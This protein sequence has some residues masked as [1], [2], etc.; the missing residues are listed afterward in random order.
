MHPILGHRR[1][2]A[3]YLGLWV[4]VGLLLAGT[5]WLAHPGSWAASL[6]VALPL[7]LLYAFQCLSSWYVVCAAPLPETRLGS[8]LATLGA[9]ATLSSLLWIAAGAG[10]S[11]L[12]ARVP[13]LA[14]AA[15]R[16]HAA[17]ALFYVSGVLLYLLALLGHYL[18]VAF[19]RSRDAER[20]A[21]EA[22]VLARD[23]EL[24]S[25]KAQLDPHF[26]FDR[27]STLLQQSVFRLLM[28]PAPHSQ[29]TNHHTLEF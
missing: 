14:E 19:E 28:I 18:L 3:L 17:L 27:Y 15:P 26:L 29:I 20:R 1:A 13:G 21:L 7:A 24:R 10:W 12:V 6:A 16:F 4:P 2:L 11:N 5:F 22:Q 25:L 8:L 23:A 9:A